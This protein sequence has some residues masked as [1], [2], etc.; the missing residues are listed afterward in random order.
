MANTQSDEAY[1]FVRQYIE[2]NPLK[3]DVLHGLFGEIVALFTP[4]D[5]GW[6]VGAKKDGDWKWFNGENSM[7]TNTNTNI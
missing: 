4:W 7:D 1:D 2:A 5:N 3:A 6:F